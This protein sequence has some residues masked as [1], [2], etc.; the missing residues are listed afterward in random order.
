[1]DGG[2]RSGVLYVVA[3][4][5]GNL[6]DL[7]ARAAATLGSV[8]LIACEDTRHSRRLLAHLGI[9]K[10]LCAYHDH[11]EAQVHARLL[12]R[13]EAGDSIALISDAGTP[14][15]SDPGFTLVRAARARDIAV[16]PIPGPS[17]LIAALCASGLPSDRFLFLGFP[18]RASSQR[19]A[20]L[21][22]V[23]SEPGTLILY[24]SGKRI[25]A[26]LEDCAAV[27]GCAR[28]AV[29]ARELTKC[30]ETFLSGTLGTLHARVSEDPDQ[31]I[32]ELV[33]MISG[34]PEQSDADQL[35]EEQ[36]VLDILCAQLPTRQA[37]DLAAQITGGAR[38][39]LYKLALAHRLVDQQAGAE[40]PSAS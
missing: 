28:N 4:P 1:M 8:D 12:A 16:V 17:A 3:T 39:R 32:G 26:T 9:E 5:I 33:L 22:A 11:N 31:R 19:R 10:P 35:R 29:I 15:I 34:A 25:L 6:A 21:E 18:P 13:L 38:N 30:F 36:R 24:E 40:L 20:F 37:A 27:L 23:A 14:L 7:S 2:I